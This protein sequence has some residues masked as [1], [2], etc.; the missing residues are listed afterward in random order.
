ML[1]VLCLV[2]A[3]CG[4]A[5]QNVLIRGIVRDSVT[6]LPVSH[7]S[8]SVGGGTRGTLTDDTGIFELSIPRSARSI[9]VSCLGYSRKTVAVNNTSLNLYAIY[10]TPQTTRLD[11]VVVTRS[12]YSKRNNPAVEFVN[13]IKERSHLSDPRRNSHYNYRKYERI[14][15]ALN[16]V[17]TDPEE[18]A[19]L[20]RYPFLSQHIDTSEITGKPILNIS[21]KESVTDVHY[22]KEPHSE[23]QIIKGV[24]SEGIDEIADQQSMQTFMTDVL[25]EIDLYD[26][27]INIL[28]NRFVSPLSPIGADFYRY[29]LTDTIA[30]DGR[31]CIELAFYPRNKSMFGFNGHVYVEFGDTT[32]AIRKVDMTVPADINLNFVDHLYISQ[33]YER[34]SDGSRL[35]SRDDL[36]MEMSIIPGTQSV[37][38]RRTVAYDGHNFA[39]QADSLFAGLGDSRTLDG[40][41]A[42]DSVYWEHARL[43]AVSKS[44]REVDHLMRRLR[45]V[46]VFY[47]GEKVVRL[48]FTG[49]IP[50]ARHSRFD[51]GPL[52]TT[53]SYNTA[54][55]VRL[56]AGGMTT[57]NLSPRWLGRGYVAYGFR[58]HRWKYQAE[59]EYSFIDKT[60]HAREFPVQ[61]LRLSHQYDIDQIGQHYLYT[62]SDNMFLSWKRMSDTRVTYRRLTRLEWMCELRNNLSFNIKLSHQRQ[63]ATRWLPFVDGYGERHSHYGE[64]S[65]TI[66]IRYAPGEKFYQTKS[67]RI[68]VNLDAP[69][70]QISHTQAIKGVAGSRFSVSKTELSAG[71][72]FWLSAF[73]YIDGIVSGGHVWSSSPYI[74]LLIPNVNLS[75]TIQPESFALMNPMEFVNDSYAQWDLTYW[76]NGLLLNQIPLL[77]RL[78]LREVVGFKGLYGHLSHRNDPQYNPELFAFPSDTD[79][80]PMDHGPYMEL[81]AGLD[82]IFSCLR[83]DYV[84]RL[85]YRNVPYPIDRSGVRI[86]LH[87]TF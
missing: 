15:M 28:Q 30:V 6:D 27:D 29:Y 65:A 63:E 18:S 13:T 12:K 87:I 19:M 78:K 45:K 8:V 47:W 56:R 46:P 58:D 20:R 74:N 83:I 82:N 14:T 1:V 41:T 44:E 67:M 24:R 66:T 80:R 32:M 50:T 35:K 60:Y 57:A 16:D 81:S 85:N 64:T 25:R 79:T 33:S 86:A 38:V 76:A 42:R 52:N 31:D 61:S 71:K 9:T 21:I 34:A 68:P 72:R 5:A 49:W 39:P 69:V 3:L 37:Y 84:W 26:N 36:T 11:E 22:R 55:G 77:K 70:L 40:A 10:L 73:G 17:S 54:E 7:A 53:L 59:L 48:F 4:A 2:V 62:N 23:R 51:F 75:Y 43:L